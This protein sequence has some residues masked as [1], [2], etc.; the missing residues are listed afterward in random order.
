MSGISYEASDDQR[1]DK[2]ADRQARD[3]SATI[4]LIDYLNARDLF[5]QND[6][7]INIAKW[8][9]NSKKYTRIHGLKI[10]E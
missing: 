1:K 8:R 10:C 6:S 4:D 2:P 3:V 5:V 7:L 9:D